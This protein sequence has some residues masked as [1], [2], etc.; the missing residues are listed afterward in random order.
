MRLELLVPGGDVQNA[1]D[2]DMDMR[3]S[4]TKN[5]MEMCAK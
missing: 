4:G 2:E 1:L 5:E 3:R